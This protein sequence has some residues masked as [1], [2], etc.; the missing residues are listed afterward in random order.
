MTKTGDYPLIY[1]PKTI[2]SLTRPRVTLAIAEIEGAAGAFSRPRPFKRH[3]NCQTYLVKRTAV[4]VLLPH[5]VRA[6]SGDVDVEV[7]NW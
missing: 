1:L 3:C 4:A 2:Q 5:G 7:G 6:N